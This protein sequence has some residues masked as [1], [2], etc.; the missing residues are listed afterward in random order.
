MDLYGLN[1]YTSKI[2]TTVDWIGYIDSTS[3][4]AR[5]KMNPNYAR[6]R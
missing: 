1:N 6:V 5:C 2:G 3:T 4:L